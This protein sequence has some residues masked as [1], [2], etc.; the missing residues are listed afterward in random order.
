MASKQFIYSQKRHIVP[1]NSKGDNEK[2]FDSVANGQ[3]YLVQTQNDKKQD[4]HVWSRV[5]RGHVTPFYYKIVLF[6]TESTQK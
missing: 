1:Q 6:S 5:N 2:S 4:F 3:K